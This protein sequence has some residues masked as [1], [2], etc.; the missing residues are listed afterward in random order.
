MGRRAVGSIHTAESDALLKIVKA[1]RLEAGVTQRQLSERLGR[2][3]NFI[4]YIERGSRRLDVVEF[5]GIA[6]ALGRDP[7]ELFASFLKA[8]G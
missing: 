5:Y 8:V 4:T 7:A 3:P 6:N 2:S 1:A